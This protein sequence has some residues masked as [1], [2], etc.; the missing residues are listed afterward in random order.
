MG[1]KKS[2]RFM[3]SEKSSL[4]RR[5]LAFIVDLIIINFVAFGAFKRLVND[6]IPEQTFSGTYQYLQQTPGKL[7]SLYIILGA[8]TLFTLIYFIY[9]E[10]KLGQT[11]GKMLLN[12]KVIS[13]AKELRLWQ[14]T[15][16]SLFMIPFFPL[17]LLWLIDP[18]YMIWN[19]KR[20]RLT[21]VLSQT[22]TIEY[23]SMRGAKW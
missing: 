14:C 5:S 23:Y 13:S 18:I 11:P 2:G 7:S 19:K 4:F 6:L 12:L 1:W 8:M 21:E 9:L 16:R 20:Q 22:K 15:V 17:I 10:Y 3:Y